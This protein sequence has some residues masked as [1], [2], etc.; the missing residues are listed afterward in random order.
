MSN[1]PIFLAGAVTTVLLL[2]VGFGGGL[3]PAKKAM[4]PVPQSQVTAAARLP[5]ARVILPYS[6][7]AASTPTVE[8][9]VPLPALSPQSEARPQ[10][11]PAK[12]VEGQNQ[13]SEMDKQADRLEQ[14][15]AEAAERERRRHERKAMREAARAKQQE[16]Q[17]R[18]EQ[19]P[20]MMA[21]SP[22]DEQQPR[23]RGF[24]GN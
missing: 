24:F 11:V 7:Q 10:V 23:W 20:G 17:A 8:A 12:A 16:E 13:A 6:A 5:P 21:F 1:G 15:K 22:G 4:Q 9:A 18:Q 2:G 14:R 3:M 19:R